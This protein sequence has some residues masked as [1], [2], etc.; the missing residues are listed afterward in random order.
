MLDSVD[1][2]RD[3]LVDA[4]DPESIILFG[5]TARGT[6]TEDSDIDLLIV[7]RTTKRPID[8]RIEAERALFDRTGPVDLFV[9][10]PE[11][12]RRLY[13]Q[14]SPFIEEIVE[15]GRVLYMRKSTGVWIDEADEELAMARILLEHGKYRGACLHGQQAVEKGLKALVIERGGRP[16][17][18][19]DILS[20]RT[21]CERIGFPIEIDLDDAVF[22]NSV[23]KGRYPSEEGLLPH[24][25][26]LP[27]DATRATVAAETVLR[28]VKQLLAPEG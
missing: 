9:Y 24:G 4:L 17:H 14:G 19:H 23:Y 18:T 28:H 25:E 22:L 21:Q 26:P 16:E 10:T 1:A 20:L 7:K 6:G 11:E 8:R 12:V 13:E 2:L 5:S 3:R 27:E 15:T